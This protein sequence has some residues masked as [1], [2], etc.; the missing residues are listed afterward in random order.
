[1][2]SPSKTTHSRI[3]SPVLE[4][5]NRSRTELDA[6][7]VRSPNMRY[8]INTVCNVV[9]SAVHQ[10]RSRESDDEIIREINTSGKAEYW[11]QWHLGCRLLVCSA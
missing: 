1:M 11:L 3:E 8:C 4:Q 2:V 9:H 6:A 10:A 5:T 7:R